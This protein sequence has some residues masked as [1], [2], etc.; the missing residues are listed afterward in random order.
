MSLFSP[1]GFIST[2]KVISP[3]TGYTNGYTI[4]INDSTPSYPGTGTTWTSIATGTTYNA[5]MINGPVWTSGTPGYFTF[6]GVNDYGD[7]GLSSTGATTSSCTFGAW[8]KTTTSSTQKVIGM[9]GKDGSGSGWSLFMSKSTTDKMTVGVVTTS[10]TIGTELLSTTT[11]VSNTWYY[12]Y[13]V[14]TQGTNLKIYVN[15]SLENTVSVTGSILRNSLTGWNLMQGNAAPLF[16]DGSISEFI[17]YN[18]VLSDSEIL[19]NF[20]YTKSKYGY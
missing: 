16:S 19:N 15:G 3:A 1:F 20:N 13:G 17:T 10:P 2:L 8:F 12:V 9:R 11:L 6:D 18:R 4:L 7:F 5:T 14:F